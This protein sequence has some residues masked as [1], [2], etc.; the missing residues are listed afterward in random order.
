MAPGTRRYSFKELN[1]LLGVLGV[2]VVFPA[3]PRAMRWMLGLVVLGSL[4]VCGE[5][6]VPP[7][8]AWAQPT[9]SSSPP[10]RLQ[11]EPGSPTSTMVGLWVT[12]WDFLTADE[13]R[14]VAVDAAALGVTDLFFQ[15]RGQADAYYRSRLEPWGEELFRG[16]PREVTEPDFDPLAVAIEAAHRRGIR[17][18]AWVNVMPLWKGTT[19]PRHWSH[20]LFTKPELRLR[21]RETGMPQP[22]DDHY[23]IV[24]PMKPEAHGHITAVVRDLVSR[25]AID[26]LHLD[27]IRFIGNREAAQRYLDAEPE[28]VRRQITDLVRLIRAALHR[29]RPGTPLTAAVWGDR[30]LGREKFMQDYTAWMRQGQQPLDGSEPACSTATARWIAPPVK[31]EWNGPMRSLSEM[32]SSKPWRTSTVTQRGSRL[33]IPPSRA[34]RFLPRMYAIPVS[35]IQQRHLHLGL[36]QT[37]QRKWRKSLTW[38]NR[39]LPPLRQSRHGSV[40]GVNKRGSPKSMSASC[41]KS[42]GSRQR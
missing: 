17:V 37:R 19:P 13:V 40:A 39:W 3:R 18:H 31:L 28:A 35:L 10:P 2:L 27:Y 9:S 25:Y 42:Q 41:W 7:G 30:Q 23:I 21:D 15:V 36:N 34:S 24:N 32:S 5:L 12:R 11:I 29:E 33:P 20:P 8:R 6:R 1:D 22:L 38:L 4:T 26:G 16:K 14:Q